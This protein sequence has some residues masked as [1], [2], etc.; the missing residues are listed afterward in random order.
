MLGVAPAHWARRKPGIVALGAAT[1]RALVLGAPL[2]YVVALAI[3]IASW[4]LPLARDQL[5]MWLGLGMAAFSLSAWRT[6]GGMLLEWLPF[7]GLLV[8]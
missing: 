4:G 2:I 8:A 7:F 1:A 3:T 6:W 5:F